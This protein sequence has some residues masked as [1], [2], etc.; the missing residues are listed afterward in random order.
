MTTVPIFVG[1]TSTVDRWSRPLNK[2]RRN[3]AR[4][5]TK[6]SVRLIS[7]LLKGFSRRNPIRRLDVRWT[8]SSL[9]ETCRWKRFQEVSRYGRTSRSRQWVTPSH[10]RRRNRTIVSQS[11]LATLTEHFP[12]SHEELRTHR[13]FK[14][15]L[16]KLWQVWF[17]SLTNELHQSIFSDWNDVGNV[18]KIAMKKSKKWRVPFIRMSYALIEPLASML[19]RAI[20]MWIYNLSSIFSQPTASVI[21]RW[22]I[23]KVRLSCSG[24]NFQTRLVDFFGLRTRSKVYPAFLSRLVRWFG[25]SSDRTIFAV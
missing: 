12:K 2:W 25:A 7:S 22:P 14:W 4:R 9:F 16:E 19:L 23:A 24:R 8:W 3:Q 15:G 6:R 17:L 21:R 13:V 5:W 18:I 1:S 11:R 20:P 10:L